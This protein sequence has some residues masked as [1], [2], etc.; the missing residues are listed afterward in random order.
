M[1][2]KT[3][4]IESSFRLIRAVCLCA[5]MGSVGSGVF[6]FVWA[7][8]LVGQERRVVYILAAGKAM[9]AFRSDRESN[10]AVEARAQVRE[11]H[12]RFF[13]LD[14]DERYNSDGLKRALYLADGS[15]KRVYD[16]LK[17]SGFYAGVVS[18]NMSERVIVDSIQLDLGGYPFRFRFYGSETLT[19]PTS[20]V[21]R[22]LVTEGYIRE[23][24][25]SE[26]DPHGLLIERWVIIDNRDLKI[27]AR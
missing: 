17:E 27:E 23:V 20:V 24:N 9:E 7:G 14:P 8:R 22:A 12:E 25:R 26:N 19:R 2:P 4:N 13:T 15:A 1:F 6:F 3:R 16:N 11:F 10:V 21:L 18:G 5:V